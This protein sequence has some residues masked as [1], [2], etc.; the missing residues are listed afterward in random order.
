VLL[1]AGQQH[2]HHITQT[3]LGVRDIA[4]T[5]TSNIGG[6]PTPW[7]R[8]SAATAQECHNLASVSRCN[9][10]VDVDC[11]IFTKGDNIYYAV[12]QPTA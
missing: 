3:L 7:L 9:L 8:G 2:Q 4:L 12:T 1:N 6:Q 11:S 5:P 10:E